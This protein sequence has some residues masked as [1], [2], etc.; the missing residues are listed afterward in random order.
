MKMWMFVLRRII[1]FIVRI[2]KFCSL[3]DVDETIST[4]EQDYDGPPIF[5]DE[6]DTFGEKTHHQHM[7][8]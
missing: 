8:Y 3:Y 4:C 6:V 7:I 1:F 5:D 2:C